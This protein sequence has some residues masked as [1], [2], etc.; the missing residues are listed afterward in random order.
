MIFITQLL[1]S[2]LKIIIFNNWMVEGTMYNGYKLSKQ[3]GYFGYPL[4]QSDNVT[5]SK[6]VE[7]NKSIWQNV[8]VS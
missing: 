5:L 1:L 6:M 8:L 7:E 2:L 4:L 3:Y